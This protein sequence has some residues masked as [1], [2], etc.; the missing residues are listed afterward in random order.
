MRGLSRGGVL[1][2]VT[3]M[4]SAVLSVPTMPE[5]T[6]T[7]KATTPTQESVPLPG[8]YD[9]RETG[10]TSPVRDQGDRGTCWAFA[11]LL[12]LENSLLPEEAW[13]FSEDHMSHDPNFTLGQENGGE[14]T[15]SMAYLLSWRG[16]V[17]EADDP[18]GDGVSPE[19]LPAVKH[20]Q[21]IRIL[22]KYDREAIKR[23][24]LAYG[25]VQS[26][27]Y[28]TMQDRE[29]TS[30]YYNSETFAYCCPQPM[31]PNHDIVIVGWDDSFPKEA[32]PAGAEADG[33]YLCENSWGTHFGEGGFFYVS[34]CDA[35][36]GNNNIAYSAVEPAD[37]YD[38]VYQSDRCGWIGQIGYG[39]ET[40]WAANVYTAASAERVAAAGFYCTEADSSY[41]LYAVRRVPAEP[42]GR[43]F[44]KRVLMAE[45]MIG[46][47]GYY[48]IPFA[49]AV[50]V[51]AGER[52]AVVLRLTTPGAVHPIAIE[53]DA[54]DGRC[55]IDLS[56]GEGYISP[57]GEQWH[58]TEREQRCNLCLK[59]YTR[60]R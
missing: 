16:P 35:N 20:T 9:P 36:I 51:A 27:L 54:G 55:A 19:G 23:A 33:A 46:D 29:S 49:Q 2:A 25:G 12:A 17:R 13:D 21:E 14:Y 53:Y 43:A 39:D 37:N 15:M 26:S 3:A 57:D 58:R 8:R 45:G 28:T 34:Y 4:I 47:A 22:P 50:D 18:Y 10:R 1:I 31:A 44:A 32:F 56:D 5:A 38:S 6:Y 42:D 40:A 52:F 48:T 30:E 11:S 24:V 41:Q 7:V 60:S 59:A